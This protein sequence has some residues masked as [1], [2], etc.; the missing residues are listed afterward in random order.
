MPEHDFIGNF[1]IDST[2]LGTSLSQK[3]GALASCRALLS[4]WVS[5]T[6]SP[7]SELFYFDKFLY[8]W[9]DVVNCFL[10]NIWD[11]VY[12]WKIHKT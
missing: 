10:E 6:T 8:D 2:V 9:R 11:N 4:D 7:I 1:L 5:G 12:I 3:R